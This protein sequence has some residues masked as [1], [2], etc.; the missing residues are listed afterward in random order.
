MHALVVGGAA[1]LWD[2]LRSLGPWTGIVVAVN[3]SIAHYPHR[4]DHAATLHPEKL[5]GWT[6]GRARR[7]G[8]LDFTS[9]SRRNPELVDRTIK[10]WSSGSSGLLAVGVAFA[11]GAERV[12][13]AGVPL[14]SEPHYFDAAAW[15]AFHLYRDA[16]ERRAEAL[17]GRVYSLSGW[18]R[19]LL[20]SPPWLQSEAA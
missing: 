3:D 15:E 6:E 20:G 8:N 17:R 1:C 14:T 10:G 12:V 11:A 19:D 13:L 16:W 18:T 4:I 7:G 2:D 9:W 5:A